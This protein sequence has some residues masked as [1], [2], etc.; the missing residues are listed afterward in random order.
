MNNDYDV[1]GVGVDRKS[2]NRLTKK[3]SVRIMSN[4]RHYSMSQNDMTRSV[5]GVRVY[6]VLVL[7]STEIAV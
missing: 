1:Q 7:H 4:S 2:K 5:A 3:M 6:V